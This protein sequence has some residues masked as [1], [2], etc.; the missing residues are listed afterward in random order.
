MTFAL[1][2]QDSE[3]R[4]VA[5]D[6]DALR[7]EFAAAAVRRAGAPAER[8]WLSSVAAV[9]SQ[10]AFTGELAQAF[11]KLVEGQL[12]VDGAR[13]PRPELPDALTGD[14]ALTL[15]FANGAALAIR[16]RSLVLAVAADGRFTEDLSC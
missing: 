4:R 7:V 2:F 6:G 10:A 8:G 12:L 11:G 1:D 5:A 16:G 14:I 9:V 13:V 3:V 15:R